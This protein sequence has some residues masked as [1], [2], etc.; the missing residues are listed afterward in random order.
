M[1]DELNFRVWGKNSKQFYPSIWDAFMASY[2]ANGDCLGTDECVVQ[3]FTG[4]FDKN[5][6]KIYVGDI[7][8][9]E[10]NNEECQL[11]AVEWSKAFAY[12]GI[13]YPRLTRLCR[14]DEHLSKNR[15]EVVGNIFENEDILK[16]YY[17][18]VREMFAVRDASNA[19]CEREAAKESGE[20]FMKMLDEMLLKEVDPEVEANALINQLKKIAEFRERNV[21]HDLPWVKV[22]SP[23]VGYL[24]DHKDEP[25]YNETVNPIYTETDGY[26]KFHIWKKNG[27][28]NAGIQIENRHIVVGDKVRPIIR[29]YDKI[30]KEILDIIEDLKKRE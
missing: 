15:L 30:P 4:L 9:N 16:E 12:F 11:G 20:R 17:E 22:E 24:L 6:V 19:A 10:L 1:K 25:D 2:N 14:I 28:Y 8:R 29:V 5:G 18:M 3:L 7:V 27:V 13:K 21:T 23:D 26:G